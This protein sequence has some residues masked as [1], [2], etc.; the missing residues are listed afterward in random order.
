MIPFRVINGRTSDSNDLRGIESHRPI[1]RVLAGRAGF[2][3][4]VALLF[5]QPGST[6]QFWRHASSQ[7]KR[8]VYTGYVTSRIS[9]GRNQVV[10]VENG[11]LELN[12][13]EYTVEWNEQGRNRF[14]SVL[15]VTD[16]IELEIET[17]AFEKALLEEADKGPLYILIEV[18]SPGGRVDF[19]KRLCAAIS[20]LKI[21]KTVAFVKGGQYGGA[22]SGA[23][24]VSLACDRIY[25][26]PETSIGAASMITHTD[27]GDVMDMKEAYGETVGEKYN[28]AWR[29]YLASLAEENN[30]PGALAKAMADKEVTVLEVKRGGQLCYVE[31]S[32]PGD[33]VIQTVNKKGD[34]LTLTAKN[35]EA[36]G[37]ADGLTESRQGLLAELK[38]SDAVFQ[39]NQTIVQSRE[40]LDKVIRRFNKLNETLDLKFKELSAKSKKGSLTRSQAIRDFDV[41]ISNTENLL[42]LKRSYPD[43]PVEEAEIL[44][45]MNII[46]AEQSSI[47]ALR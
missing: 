22:Y 28:S 13:A 18:D 40:E 9:E 38:C 21:C 15:P 4:S 35:A 5:W 17:A 27:S 41:L 45:L 30:R 8:Y 6:A 44:E 46:K 2:R 20:G 19:A 39:E 11:V 25:M 12:L 24:A 43:I 26:V 14:I 16:A 23:A 32:L 37:V 29:N 34:L 31:Q 47:K 10:T 3:C 36:F 42:K 7:G 33:Q 1:L